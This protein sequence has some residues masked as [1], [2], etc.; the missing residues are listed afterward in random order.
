M[1]GN[2]LALAGRIRQEINDVGRVV[3][4]TETIWQEAQRSS[5]D[6][7]VD[8]TALNLH[9]FYAGVER[10]LETIASVVDQSKPTGSNWHQELLRQMS[11]AIPKVRPPV[12]T[13]E[14][15]DQLDRYRGFRHV[16]RNVYTYNLDPA[17]VGALVADLPD[18]SAATFSELEKFAELL[19]EIGNPNE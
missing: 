13:I 8:A 2:Y 11:A 14:T 19:Q 7:L 9:G 15:R 12:L 5:D 4:R 18:V 6:Y 3:Q 17:Q 16:V 1:N 10:V